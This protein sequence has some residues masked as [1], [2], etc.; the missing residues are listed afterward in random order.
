M[1]TPTSRGLPAALTGLILSAVL[2]APPA[3]GQVFY[4][5]G[6]SLDSQTYGTDVLPVTGYG[7]T[8]G[9]YG[10]YGGGGYGV[11]D[12]G[13]WTTAGGVTAYSPA[14]PSAD[15]MPTLSGGSQAGYDTYSPYGAGYLN[16]S[17]NGGTGYVAVPVYAA[18]PVA[19]VPVARG[20]GFV[21]VSPSAVPNAVS[22]YHIPG[23]S[24]D[25]P[26]TA[27]PYSGMGYGGPT[28]GKF[29]PVT[30]PVYGGQVAAY[31]PVVSAYSPGVTAY[32][33]GVAAVGAPVQAGGH[34]VSPGTGIVGQP[35]VYLEG[36]PVRNF[37]R[38][39]SP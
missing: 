2:A 21:P 26:V 33:P 39:I 28:Y 15:V 29:S 38:A 18:R 16:G 9:G 1:T 22:S 4:G 24:Y 31:A 10:G 30:G 25:L 27:A 17:Y 20:A 6:L 34:G 11:S 23:T 12:Y 8:L 5:P 13:G 37:L 14:V 32:S 36:Q 3:F 35:T 7:T 19:T